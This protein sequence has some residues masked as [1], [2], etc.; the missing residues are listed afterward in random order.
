[1]GIDSAGEEGR[2]T[3]Y[4]RAGAPCS[5]GF[6]AEGSEPQFGKEVGLGAEGATG[7]AFELL[8]V[9][10]EFVIGV[11]AGGGVGDG[12]APG[13]RLPLSSGVQGGGLRRWPAED[14]GL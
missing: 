10:A 7:D 3:G 4:S 1:M 13:L 8:H 9:D 2:E 11:V 5:P 6:P 12:F 14:A